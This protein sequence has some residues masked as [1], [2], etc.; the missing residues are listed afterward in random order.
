MS[1]ATDPHTSSALKTYTRSIGNDIIA[2]SD[3]PQF[4]HWRCSVDKYHEMVR[5]G[6]FH[7][8]DRL[9]LLEGLIVRKHPPADGP[10]YV[11]W[12]CSVEQYHEMMSKGILG[13]DDRVELL[14]G[15]IVQKMTISPLHRTITGLVRDAIQLHLTDEYFIDSQDPIALAES[16]P[17]PDV[18][19]TRGKRLDFIG[20]HAS[21]ADV[22]LVVEVADSS[23]WVDRN[24]KKSTYA[25]NQIAVYWIVNLVDH[26]V[27]V[28]RDP[29][30]APPGSDYANRDV[31]TR[32][33]KIPLV[34][35]GRTVAEIAV[36]L[37]I[38]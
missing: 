25:A 28:Y 3:A 23:L 27:E 19:V 5:W 2:A 6:I 36:S 7:P 38:P 11:L 8:D 18:V 26:Q 12:R 1:L 20:R 32:A 13:E 31:Y 30:N 14:K 21:P 17:E 34:I 9:E 24:D 4:N 35:D 29:E 16:E 33:D 15:W 10:S 37:I 22:A